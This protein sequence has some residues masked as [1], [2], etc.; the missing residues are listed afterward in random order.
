MKHLQL[1]LTAAICSILMQGLS[2]CTD[3]DLHEETLDSHRTGVAYKFNMSNVAT[4]KPDT[5]CVV[6]NRIVDIWKSSM[7]V[8]AKTGQGL[9]LFNPQQMEFGN[10]DSVATVTDTLGRFQLR[11]GTYKF[12]AF[13]YG[14]N[15]LDYAG[16]DSFLLRDEAEV[17][18]LYVKYRVHTL[19]AL[20]SI[21]KDETKRDRYMNWSDRNKYRGDITYMRPSSKAICRDVVTMKKLSDNATS[22]ISFKP[23][24]ITQNVTMSF[25]IQ[26]IFNDTTK[27]VIKEVYAEISG[28]PVRLDLMTGYVDITET[29][30]MMFPM[31]VT[32]D[33]KNNTKV[34]CTATIDVPTLVPSTSAVDTRGP[35][36]LQ[37]II[38]YQDSSNQMNKKQTKI[39]LYSLLT[40]KDGKKVI[41][42]LYK[43]TDDGLHAVRDGATKTLKITVPPMN[44][45][46]SESAI[47]KDELSTWVEEE[48]VVVRI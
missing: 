37:L 5:M 20:A 4:N 29:A 1:L 13:T 27:F 7:K 35:G 8:S 3:V 18:E 22:T 44:E 30:K 31:K 46:E 48:P 28:V 36:L 23:E 9:Y 21:L 43:F 6:A 17:T 41:P 42:S 11:S 15:E 45:I 19:E 24:P 2:S 12:L 14:E 40:K 10:P 25:D 33:S 47:K 39:N 16:V 32:K 38:Y 34:T 26:K